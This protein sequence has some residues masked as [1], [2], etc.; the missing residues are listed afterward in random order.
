M[1]KIYFISGL[2]A[3]SLASC[4]PNFKTDAPSANGLDFSRYVAV[5]N[6]LTAGYS[7]GTLYR[8]GQQT[9][10][11]AILAEQF[12][13]LG[14]GTFTQPLLPG[15]SGW[16]GPKRVLGY[17]S[18]CGGAPSL[19][20]VIYSGNRDTAGSGV[21][22]A[23]QGPYNNMGIPG[24][25]AIDFLFPGYGFANPYAGRIFSA[26]FARGV[27]EIDNIPATFFTVWLGA[28]DVLGYALS[29]GE[30]SNTPS[31]PQNISDVNS[32]KIA[33][34]SV[35]NTMTRGGAKG[36]LL[37][38]PDITSIP[39]FTTI[40]ANSLQL[41]AS[42]AAQLAAAYS[43]AGMTFVA[44]SNYF[45]VEDPNVPQL[46]FRQAKP[47]EI[48]LL[49]TPSDSLRCGGWGS[50]RPIPKE[51]VLTLTEIN[52]IRE[53]TTAFNNH[54]RA[55]AIQSQL[56]YV[57][58]AAYLKTLG[59]GIRFNGVDYTAQFVSGGAFSLD[60]IH[61]TPRGYAMAANEIIRTING[62]YNSTVPTV[63]ANKFGGVRFP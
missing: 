20:P 38:I 39:Y 4:K 45:V 32:F 25:R 35:V 33:Y 61:L 23:A 47:G 13:L 26:P 49:T 3:L 28:N 5:G 48:I 43:G 29:G 56:A 34:D 31:S 2:A 53:A 63:D 58:M 41:N 51:Y 36:A 21:N 42:Q 22:I 57:D 17:S 7:D 14:G 9:S 55:K 19:S 27:D 8:S 18:V 6:S 15:E 44:G 59:T 16:P 30:G 52:K 1:K 37:N 12:R 50:T 62:Y 60:G 46:G 11:P 40:P 24:I 54:I 10:Y